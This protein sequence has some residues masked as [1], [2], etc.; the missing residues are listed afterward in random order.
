MGKRE[1]TGEFTISGL[2]INFIH[3]FNFFPF[4]IQFFSLGLKM[5][6]KKNKNGNIY[7][8]IFFFSRGDELEMAARK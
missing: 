2:D 8:Y 5:K 4:S 1:D 3:F 7:I 6:G